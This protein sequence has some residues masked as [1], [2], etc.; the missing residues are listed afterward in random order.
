M[1][2]AFA[3]WIS[4]QPW[5]AAIVAACLG[6]LSPQG[7]TPFAVLAAAVPTLIA[8]QGNTRQALGIVLA[9]AAA[10]T[11]SL[12]L[13]G[14]AWYLAGCFAI[15]VFLVPFVLGVVLQ[16]TGSLP[17][18]FQLAVL[19]AF[20]VLGGIYLWLDQPASVW[21]KLL[22]QA[23]EA[24][25]QAGVEF[26][27]SL[28]TALARTMWGTYLALWLL[29]TLCAL[30]VARWWQALLV[31][32]GSF[33]AE[34]RELR[35]GKVLGLISIAVIV[36]AALADVGFWDALAWSA[37]TALAFQGLAAAHR[38]KATG[39]LKRG[40]LVAI[41]VFLIMPLFSF[42]TVSLLAGWGLADN[43]RRLRA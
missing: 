10:V 8:L 31:S 6:V 36:A 11:T 22:A 1:Q 17:L 5:R 34:F 15:A 30:F 37:V 19:L 35:L 33:G 14:Y 43:W 2:R 13:G 4:E 39:R 21:E 20:A 29:S 32:P 18:A 12:L 27:P 42:I 40:W 24:L 16:R 26:D 28:M 9:G 38:Q 41:Y 23:G 25:Q 3:A 7:V